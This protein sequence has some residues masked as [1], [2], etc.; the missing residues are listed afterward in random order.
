MS[1]TAKRG[2]VGGTTLG[3]F[4]IAVVLALGGSARSRS[5]SEPVREI[6]LSARDVAFNEVN[7]TLALRPGE[8]VRFVVRNDD[9]GVLHS[10]TLPGIDSRVHFVRSGE[11]VAFE[12]TVP[13]GGRF[14]Y[15]CPQHLPKMRGRIEVE[16]VE[17]VGP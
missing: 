7:P 16:A 17:D 1:R 8:R 10:I 14:E 6:V 5:E 4:A 2:L 13:E 15:T 9:P 11:E 12:V 3:A